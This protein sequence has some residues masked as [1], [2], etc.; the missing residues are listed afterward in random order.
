MRTNTM[1]C[2]AALAAFPLIATGIFAACSAGSG[3]PV[4]GSGKGGGGGVEVP[5]GSGFDPGD[6]DTGMEQCVGKDFPGT[7]PPLDVYILLDATGSMNGKDDSPEVWVPVTNAIKQLVSNEMT[8]G[9][10]VGM[11]YLPVPPP[12]GFRIPG[13]CKTPPKGNMP[14]LPDTGSCEPLAPGIGAMIDKV[15]DLACTK[16]APIE[17]L[18]AEC[19]LYGGCEP[20][21]MDILTNPGS[22]RGYCNGALTPTVSCDPADYGEPVVPIAELPGNKNAITDALNKKKADGD[23]TPTQ[24][25]LEGTMRYILQWAKDRPDHLVHVLFATDGEP[26]DC[27]YNDIDGA[28]KVAEKAFKEFP[29]VPTFVLGLGDL[30]KLDKIAIA[31]GTEKTYIANGSSVAAELVNVFNEIR[32]NGACQ[33]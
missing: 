9:I 21:P 1:V 24:P 18:L 29:Y 33:F 22:P 26:N 13:T 28:A 17:V 7:L 6:Q 30:K 20:F 10:G 31:G 27:T 3:E 11:T 19:G 25:A 16:G 4:G 2:L 32:A 15:C 8:K 5:D 23:A 12:D 14:C